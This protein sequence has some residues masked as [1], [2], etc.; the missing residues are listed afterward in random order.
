MYIWCIQGATMNGTEGGSG[1]ASADIDREASKWQSRALRTD[2]VC[3][4]LYPILYAINIIVYW[5][6]IIRHRQDTIH[7]YVNTHWIFYFILCCFKISCAICFLVQ[8]GYWEHL[9][10]LSR[11]TAFTSLLLG[12]CT[13]ILHVYIFNTL[14]HI[15][16]RKYIIYRLPIT[17]NSGTL[18]YP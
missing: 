11:I 2:L 6:V 5:S 3:R 10:N 7:S 15:L 14:S 16:L 1:Q 8:W 9:T 12:I 18:Q 17:Q 13:L 4:L